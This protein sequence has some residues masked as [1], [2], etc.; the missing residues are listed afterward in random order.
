MA[1]TKEQFNEIIKLLKRI[2]S[3]SHDF[4]H[5]L[6]V[7]KTAKELIM[8]GVDEEV[9][10]IAALVHDLIDEKLEEK[11]KEEE[12]EEFLIKIG[13]EEEKV[14]K[15][16]EVSKSISFRKGIPK[17][18]L[19]L[20]AKI[21]QDADRLD[22]LGAIGIARAF[23]YA[24]EKGIPLYDEEIKPDFKNPK[25]KTAINHF[26]EKLLKLKELMNTEKA[27]RLAEKRERF[28]IEFLEEFFKELE[29]F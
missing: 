23:C 2:K 10:E 25:G 9:V 26:F 17:E 16:L 22:A 1:I 5:A 28:M 6:R 20:E 7:Y 13:I 21:V 4:L 11:I 18:K 15:A 27:K 8:E 29:G 19:T 3:P 14:K 24:G 12:L